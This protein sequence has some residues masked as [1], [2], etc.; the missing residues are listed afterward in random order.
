MAHGRFGNL[1]PFL[2]TWFVGGKVNKK[3]WLQRQLQ[4]GGEEGGVREQ[5][6]YIEKRESK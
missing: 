2:W 4:K 3:T 1:P 6:A 5:N